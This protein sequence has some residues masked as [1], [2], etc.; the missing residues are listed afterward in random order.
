[1]LVTNAT[2][3]IG[4]MLRGTRGGQHTLR[5]RGAE[6]NSSRFDGS[7]LV[8]G[9]I[10]AALSDDKNV[11]SRDSP[12]AYVNNTPLIAAVEHGVAVGPEAGAVCI[13]LRHVRR[14]IHA[15]VEVPAFPERVVAVVRSRIFPPE[16]RTCGNVAPG[17]ISTQS[18]PGDDL[19]QLLAWL[20]K[21]G[22]MMGQMRSVYMVD[23]ALG[24][25]G[26]SIRTA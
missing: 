17:P 10:I 2:W 26:Y 12:V 4:N 14:G 18:Y 13:V 11:A 23:E 24:Q 25:I 3:K 7:G 20:V 5:L 16:Q 21:I 8:G 9:D 19:C 6:S 15:A 22:G 1:M